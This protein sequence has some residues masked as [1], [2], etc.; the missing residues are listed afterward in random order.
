M[1]DEAARPPEGVPLPMVS[2]G[3][4][5]PG[6]LADLDS[7]ENDLS[8]AHMFLGRYITLAERSPADN[9][10]AVS[11]EMQALWNA[12]LIAYRRAFTSGRSLI[13]P[14]TSRPKLADQ[15][16]DL[17]PAEARPVHDSLWSNANQHVAHRVSDHEQAI[18]QVVLAPEGAKP[19]IVGLA[20]LHA[21]Y[22][23]PTIEDAKTALDLCAAVGAI[24]QRELDELTK[25]STSALATELDLASLYKVWEQGQ[26]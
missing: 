4:A 15:I 18:V 12:A 9:D 17:L 14:K 24:V 20:R 5:M 7:I 3:G 11:V 21:R 1:K 10:D 23:G 6:W 16:L 25:G 22:I 8:T 26:A 19:E 2:I 13:L